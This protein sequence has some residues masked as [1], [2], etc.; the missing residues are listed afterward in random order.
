MEKYSCI[1]QNKLQIRSIN[2][3]DTDNIVRWRN[4]ERVRNNFL[5]RET[6]TPEGHMNWMRNKVDT[7]EV[8]QFIVGVVE[9]AE[10]NSGSPAPV[11]VKDIGSVYFRDIDQAEMSA[12]Y[13]VFIGE[14]SAIGFGYGN[15]IAS[16]A[17][18]YAKEKMHLKTLILRVLAD[19]VSALKSYENAGFKQYEIHK[20]YIDGRDLVFMKIE[21]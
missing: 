11:S 3:E 10:D 19:N 4:N 7:G 5:Y 12:E 8:E 6:F 2:D 20:D 16:W 14:D 15:M 21:F 18:G 9:T 1:Y 13:G 17:V